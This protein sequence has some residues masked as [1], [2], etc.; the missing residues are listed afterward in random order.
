MRCIVALVADTLSFESI[1]GRESLYGRKIVDARIEDRTL[2]LSFDNG[3]VL[4]LAGAGRCCQAVYFNCD[5]SVAKI[6]GGRLRS[7]ELRPDRSRCM[8]ISAPPAQAFLEIS[9]YECFITI[10]AHCDSPPSR[11]GI[12][13]QIA[14]RQLH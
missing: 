7:I 8:G 6:V 2:S 11:D 5:D 3:E 9:T 13:L 12:V 1:D 14:R 4:R 10:R